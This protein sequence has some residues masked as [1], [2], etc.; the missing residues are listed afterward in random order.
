[1]TRPAHVPVWSSRPTRTSPPA[2][3]TGPRCSARSV[4]AP[5]PTRPGATPGARP[6]DG[7]AVIGRLAPVALSDHVL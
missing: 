3:P 4:S 2:P 6:A 5:C 1:M 7:S